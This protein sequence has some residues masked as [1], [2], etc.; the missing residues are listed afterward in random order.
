[1]EAT[2]KIEPYNEEAMRLFL[3][4]LISKFPMPFFCAAYVNKWYKQGYEALK[5]AKYGNIDMIIKTYNYTYHQIL[6]RNN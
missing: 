1:M 2:V 5:V 4:F 3:A 6:T